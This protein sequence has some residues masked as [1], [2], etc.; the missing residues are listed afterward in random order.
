MKPKNKPVDYFC[1]L[2][3]HPLKTENFNGQQKRRL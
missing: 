2:F 1:L 3:G